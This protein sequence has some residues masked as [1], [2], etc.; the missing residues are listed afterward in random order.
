MIR[1]LINIKIIL[2]KAF[3]Y[4]FKYVNNSFLEDIFFGSSRIFFLFIILIL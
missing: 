4:M 1:A 3:L 2:F